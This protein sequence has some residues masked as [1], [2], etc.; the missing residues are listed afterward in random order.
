[1]GIVLSRELKDS[2]V[3]VSRT[4]DRV[5]SVKLGIGETMV[6]V[7]MCIH[8]KWAVK[9]EIRKH[10]QKDGARARDNSRMRKGG[11]WRRPRRSC[12]DHALGKLLRGYTVAGEW[13][14]RTSKVKW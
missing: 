10:Y 13:E 5:M 2:L 14:R 4:S 11:C 7:I 9:G 6:N 3:S 1:M 8:S 12:G